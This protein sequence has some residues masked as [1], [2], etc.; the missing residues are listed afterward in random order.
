MRRRLCAFL[1]FFSLLP[2]TVNPVAAHEAGLV[3]VGQTVGLEIRTDGVYVVKFDSEDGDSP[4]EAA[5]LKVGDRI[6]SVD[7]EPV[8]QAED[9]RLRVEASRGESLLFLVDRGEK[10]MSFPVSPISEEGGWRIG[11][12][13]RDRIRGLGT[14]TF[15]DPESGVFGAL[16]HGVNDAEGRGQTILGGRATETEIVSVRK[17]AVGTPGALQGG[18]QPGRCLGRVEENTPQGI[19][20]TAE[21]SAWEG[22]PLQVAAREEVSVGPAEIW[23]SVDG[24]GTRRYQAVIEGLSFSEEPCKNLRIRVTD[25]ALLACTGG[26]VQGMSGS[27]IIQNGKL[28][29]AVTHVLIRD[30]TRGYG[31][32]LENMLDASALWQRAHPEAA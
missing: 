7:G 20:G 27:P 28:V 26:I 18:M 5:G 13:V 32:L 9:I 1:M 12:Y 10:T 17:G 29:G 22:E 2:L 11:V 16:G 21:T 8:Q 30:P 3:P 31:I 6:R 23:C 14:V 4:A 15:F 19:F 25:E 24:C